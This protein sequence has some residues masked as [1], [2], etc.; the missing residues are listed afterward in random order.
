M[1]NIPVNKKE[2][3]RLRLLEIQMNEESINSRKRMVVKKQITNESSK[4]K[5][6]KNSDKKDARTQGGQQ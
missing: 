2:L 3:E 1:K 4:T 6:E 5:K